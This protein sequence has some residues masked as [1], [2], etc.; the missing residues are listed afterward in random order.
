MEMRLIG[1]VS[2]K[3]VMG[4]TSVHTH[5]DTHRLSYA[6]LQRRWIFLTCAHSCWGKGKSCQAE[7]EIQQQHQL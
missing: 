4:G 3:C 1:S 2:L 6:A 7:N 5:T